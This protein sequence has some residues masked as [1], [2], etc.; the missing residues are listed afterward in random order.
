MKR[1]QYNLNKVYLDVDKSKYYM[2]QESGSVLTGED[3]L[4]DFENQ[5]F[6]E[7][8]NDDWELIEV[9]LY[10]GVWKQK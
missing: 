3:W 4:I 10:W 5:N 2:N 6:Y 1:K 7:K 8:E 9:Y